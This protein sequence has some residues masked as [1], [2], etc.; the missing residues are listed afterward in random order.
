LAELAQ[1]NKATAS[2]FNN[3]ITKW[4]AENLFLATT[5]TGQTRPEANEAVVRAN[6]GLGEI[7]PIVSWGRVFGLLFREGFVWVSQD[8]KFFGAEVA[9]TV[10]VHTTPFNFINARR[11]IACAMGTL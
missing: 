9:A 3:F 4:Y 6:D 11:M 5:A 10:R 2:V 7:A 8:K 1:S